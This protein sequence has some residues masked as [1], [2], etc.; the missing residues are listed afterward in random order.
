MRRI[1]RVLVLSTF[2]LV[3]V[4][5]SAFAQLPVRIGAKAGLDFANLGGDA[6]DLFDVN[7]DAKTGFSAGAFFGVDLMPMFRVQLEGQ[8]VRKGAKFTEQDPEGDVEAKVKLDYIE[9]MVPLTVLVPTEFPITP[10]FYAG[11]ALGIETGCKFSGEQG[12]ISLDFDCQELDVET[13]SIDFGVFFGAGIDIG[14][15]DLPFAATLDVLYNLGLSD[16]NDVA[17]T[18]GSIKNRNI[19][20]LAG[21]AI[22]A[23]G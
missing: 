20:I 2:T 5:G 1:T 4:T 22:V 14:F 10:R 13:K 21:L 12:G 23:G 3:F 17:G 19:Q 16:I 18:T 11:P 15:Q 7:F 8:Y 9:V 6:E